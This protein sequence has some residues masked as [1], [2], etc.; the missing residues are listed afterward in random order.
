MLVFETDLSVGHQSQPIMMG[1]VQQESEGL[2]VFASPELKHMPPQLAS[3][4]MK[5][6]ENTQLVSFSKSLLQDF[7]SSFQLNKRD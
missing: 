5:Q 2:T 6:F 4:V 3:V 1:E 7:M